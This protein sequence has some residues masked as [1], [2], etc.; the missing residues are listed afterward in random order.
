M[1]STGALTISL[2]LAA[3]VSLAGA[4]I[5]AWLYLRRRREATVPQSDIPDAIEGRHGLT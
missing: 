2:S 4:A 3:L 5:A 1:D